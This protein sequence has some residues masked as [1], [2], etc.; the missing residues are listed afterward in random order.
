[1][2]KPKLKLVYSSN[3]AQ[4]APRRFETD[5]AGMWRGHCKTRESA[6]LASIKHIVQDGYSKSTITDKFTGEVVARV[7]LST[8]RTRAVVEVAKPF[9]KVGK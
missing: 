8:D 2:P 4:S 1:M 7:R 3:R 5:Y 6:I 9:R